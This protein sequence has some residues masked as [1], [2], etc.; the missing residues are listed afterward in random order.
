MP[1]KH[2]QFGIKRLNMEQD[3]ITRTIKNKN[4][5]CA[6]LHSVFLLI[7]GTYTN[8]F[9]FMILPRLPRDVFDMSP[10]RS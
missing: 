9:D 3:S 8:S 4:Y 6:Y 2:E 10:N 7:N 5:F 1:D